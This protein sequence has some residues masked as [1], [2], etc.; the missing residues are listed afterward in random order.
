[1]M[2]MMIEENKL[3]SE[4]HDANVLGSSL[5]VLGVS[6]QISA[7]RELISGFGPVLTA[8]RMKMVEEITH[9]N[10]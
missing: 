9:Y 5:P 6:K 10:N 8:V 4:Y 3:L 7:A 2:M 1:M